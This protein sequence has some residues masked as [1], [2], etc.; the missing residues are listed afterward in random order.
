MRQWCAQQVKALVSKP[1][2]LIYINIAHILEEKN[3][4]NCPLNS[5]SIL[6]HTDTHHMYTHAHTH[7]AQIQGSY[8]QY[9]DKFT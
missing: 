6:Y 8:T 2:D 5:I 7:I 3:P 4:E 9:I 1:D